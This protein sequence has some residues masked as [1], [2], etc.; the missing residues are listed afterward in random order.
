MTISSQMCQTGKDGTFPVAK[1]D[2]EGFSD[3]LDRSKPIA[4]KYRPIE[5]HAGVRYVN[6]TCVMIRILTKLNPE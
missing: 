6:W 5:T 1:Y 3:F 2:I 4:V